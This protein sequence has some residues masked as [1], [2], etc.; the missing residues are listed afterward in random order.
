MNADENSPQTGVHDINPRH[1]TPSAS[2]CETTPSKRFSACGF[3]IYFVTRGL[4]ERYR[5]IA[6]RVGEVVQRIYFSA[7]FVGI[8]KQTE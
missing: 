6:L 5:I 2:D 1:H 4:R 3:P 8:I 7:S